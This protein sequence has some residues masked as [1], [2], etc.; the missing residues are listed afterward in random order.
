[1]RSY[2]NR[3]RHSLHV[4]PEGSE[5]SHCRV[6]VVSEADIDIADIV[7]VDDLFAPL[8]ERLEED[9]DGH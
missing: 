5:R 6:E 4:N 2:E 3:V 9:L 7:F 1:M 8:R